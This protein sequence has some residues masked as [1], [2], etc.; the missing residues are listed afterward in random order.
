M[1]LINGTVVKEGDII[2]NP[3]LADTIELLTKKSNVFYEDGEIGSDMVQELND[4]KTKT[5]L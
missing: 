2:T 1:F 3:D 4:V 5:K